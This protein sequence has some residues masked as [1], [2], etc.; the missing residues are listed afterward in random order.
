[1]IGNGVDGRGGKPPMPELAQPDARSSS[2]RLGIQATEPRTVVSNTAHIP[3]PELS[4]AKSRLKEA[5][6]DYAACEWAVFPVHTPRL[7]G[8]CSCNRHPCPSV[9]KHPR[10]RNGLKDATTNK[11]QIRKW[12]ERWPD[13]NIGIACGASGLAVEA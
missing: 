5:A 10:T 7:G 3:P 4:V 11:E 6:L 13:A 1:M 2:F 8:A 12:W 9:G